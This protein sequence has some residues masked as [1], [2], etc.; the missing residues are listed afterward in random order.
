[1]WPTTCLTDEWEEDLRNEFI[2]TT[3]EGCPIQLSSSFPRKR[4]RLLWRKRRRPTKKEEQKR[5]GAEI[6]WKKVSNL[7]LVEFLVLRR[8]HPDHR[9]VELLVSRWLPFGHLLFQLLVP[10]QLLE[11]LRDFWSTSWAPFE[12]GGGQMA[13]SVAWIFPGIAW[14]LPKGPH[15]IDIGTMM[16]CHHPSIKSTPFWIALDSSNMNCFHCGKEIVRGWSQNTICHHLSDWETQPRI[17]FVS[18]LTNLQK[19]RLCSGNHP[20]KLLGKNPTSNLWA[21]SYNRE[22]YY[23]IRFQDCERLH[24]GQIGLLN[25]KSTSSLPH[26]PRGCTTV[27]FPP[28]HNKIFPI[29]VA[30]LGFLVCEE[31]F[32]GSQHRSSELGRPDASLPWV[33][34]RTRWGPW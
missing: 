15:K 4:R 17:R 21:Y 13:W 31:L 10:G 8:I 32:R 25:A 9:L 34:H 14:G 12:N 11:T 6:P 20:R 18:H 23:S 33:Y 7:W 19:G 1:M 27:I 29:P 28:H 3:W 2:E 5:K 24:Y 16:G 26:R 22:F 30:S